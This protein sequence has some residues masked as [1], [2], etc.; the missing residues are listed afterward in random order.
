MIDNNNKYTGNINTPG[1]NRVQELGLPNMEKLAQGRALWNDYILEPFNVLT[2]P[3]KVYKKPGGYDYVESSYMDYCFK[4]SSPLY[5]HR[6]LDSH[7]DMENGW[8][9][10]FVVTTDRITGNSELGA[11]SARIAC[12]KGTSE[13]VDL[14]N[15]VKSA[16][17]RA[18]KNAQA[19]FGH[20]ADVYQKRESI[21]T[22][23]ER[24]RYNNLYKDIKVLE[25]KAANIMKERWAELGTDWS[26]F[27]DQWEEYYQTLEERAA[28]K[29]SLT[30]SIKS[31]LGTTKNG[32]ITL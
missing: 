17:S 26:I 14:G 10:C 15:N 20:A 3:E 11:D 22:D 8:V 28:N 1:N 30:K 9:T 6:L 32:K 25:S 24:E 16:L 31:E 21:P 19:K 7:I 13:V 29:P 4:K 18:I 23:D 12:K 27:L 2:P 5:E